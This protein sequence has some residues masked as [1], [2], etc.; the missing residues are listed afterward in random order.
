M[1]SEILGE[2]GQTLIERASKGLFSG[3]ALVRRGDEIVFSGAYGFAARAWSVRNAVA[4]RFRVASVGKMFTAAAVLRLIEAGAFSLDTSAVRLLGLAGAKIPE[5]VTITHLL[6]H[7]SGIA[8]YYDEDD[9]ED[10]WDRLWQERPIYRMRTLADYYPMF[11]GKEPLARPGERFHYSG[12]GY[13]LLGMVIEAVTGQTYF[14]YV[15]RD[16]F[17]R[18]GM[19][20]SGFIATDDVEPEVAEGYTLVG[21]SPGGPKW[22][23]NIYSVTPQAA[24]DG[25]VV[26][27]AD[28]LID[29]MQALRRGR[30][31]SPELAALMIK[32]HAL[33][34]SAASPRGH[35]LSY[36]FANYVM[37]DDQGSVV[38]TGHTGE[39]VGV[40][41]RLYHF[42]EHDLDV[43]ILGNQSG[44]AGLPGKTITDILL[45]I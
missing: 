7:T 45:A 5:E 24:S 22:Q 6:T 10:A 28:D 3:V 30:V 42:V 17:A 40:S 37:L 27:T 23:R 41:C 26:S 39:E 16:I 2:F 13:I 43:A 32:P 9:G 44:C 38:R 31:V 20:R 21:D 33:V 25:G 14:D 35:S 34:S 11:A 18:L 29:F 19:R 36:G 4:T 8:D 15:T 12:A 1:K